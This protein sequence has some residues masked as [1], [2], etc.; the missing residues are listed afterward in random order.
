MNIS[1]SL[2]VLALPL[3][4]L[5]TIAAIGCNGAGGQT[6]DAHE[7]V[8][9]NGSEAHIPMPAEANIRTYLDLGDDGHSIAFS[10]GLSWPDVI[11][12]YKKNL[13]TGDWNLVSEEI[14]DRTEGERTASWEVEGYG[15]KV[16][17]EIT[18]FGGRQGSNMSGWMLVEEEAS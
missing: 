11:D 12:F 5:G 7:L 13:K 6:A 9:P 4:L 15:V 8:L 14:P 18:A 17:V 2:I 1:R 16:T 10:P 3:L